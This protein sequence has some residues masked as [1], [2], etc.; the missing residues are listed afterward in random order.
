MIIKQLSLF[1]ELTLFLFQEMDNMYDSDNNQTNLVMVLDNLNVDDKEL[2]NDDTY[3]NVTDYSC[4]N[5]S[6]ESD[7]E[8]QSG[9]MAIVPKQN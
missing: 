3:T 7:F 9:A 4:G 2:V 5:D 8:D 1:K 6:N